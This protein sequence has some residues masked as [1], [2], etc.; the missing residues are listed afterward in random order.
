MTRSGLIVQVV[1]MGVLE[2]HTERR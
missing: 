2:T 1:M